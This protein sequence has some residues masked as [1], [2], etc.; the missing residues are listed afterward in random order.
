MTAPVRMSPPSAPPPSPPP[1]DLPLAAPS[2]LRRRIVVLVAA[3]ALTTIAGIFL[4]TPDGNG[5]LQTLDDAAAFVLLAV[6]WRSARPAV[7]LVSMLLPVVAALS[8]L[9]SSTR[10][11]RH[12]RF[13]AVG[14]ALAAVAAVV[15]AIVV[16][17]PAPGSLAALH[18]ATG[19]RSFPSV[20][21]A[22]ASASALT[23]VA[24]TGR[25]LTA[26]RVLTAGT[27]VVVL[28]ALRIATGAAWLLDEVSG[29]VLGG[30]A[31]DVVVGWRQPVHGHRERRPAVIAAF[32]LVIGAAT[33]PTGI[34]YSSYLTAPGNLSVSER[35]I[36]FLRD[37]G[38]GAF[39]DRAE[40][41]WLW[42]HLP[43][44]GGRLAALPDAPLDVGDASGLPAPLRPALPTPLPGEGQWTVAARAADGRAQI[45]TTDLRP[46]PAHPTIVAAV[47]WINQQVTRLHLVAGLHEPGGGAGPSGARIPR[48]L[49]DQVLAAFNS[50][51]RMKDTPGGALE[52]GRQVRS[53][54]PGI[55]T[56]AIRADGTATIGA[57]GTDIDPHARYLAVRQNLHLM[58]RDGRPVDGVATNTGGR[59]G[60]IRNTLP[61]W[62][63]GLG[64][65]PGGDLVYVAGSEL[66]LGVLAATLE[67]A[68][69]GTAMELDIHPTAVTFNLFTHRPQPLGHKLLP[70]MTKPAD[71]YLTP[72]WRDFFVIMPA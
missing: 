53:L 10:D 27:A 47:A 39:V 22:M 71:R 34:R 30:L 3:M 68:G 37:H 17:R 18:A 59:W 33:V 55:A 63:S 50:G 38:L 66:T 45:A 12:T 16:R 24:C 67:R 70:S 40:S 4:V 44:T 32:A 42:W 43:P 60:R 52:E 57:W 9:V 49:Q 46:D 23:I 72:D 31:A 48:S 11:R 2:P 69:A 65:T 8:M 19:E 29:V 61:T 7:A 36:E 62:R 41:W 54:V 64:I 6:G 28:S 13:P 25:G 26:R 1:V 21:A 56:V 51:Y 15:P 35:S 5:F 14:V 20:A 58:V